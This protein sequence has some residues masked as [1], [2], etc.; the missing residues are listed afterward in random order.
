VPEDEARHASE[1][2]A[3]GDGPA[4]E[5]A[6]AGDVRAGEAVKA[7]RAGKATDASSKAGQDDGAAPAESGAAPPEP[8]VG[9]AASDTQSGAA[10]TGPDADGGAGATK[11]PLARAEEER[12]EYLALA[13]R[14]KADFE[15]YRRRAA[16][17]V[18]AAGARGRADVVREL[19]PVLD[20]LERALESVD[21]AEAP[22]AQGVRL[23]H[24]ELA[25]VLSRNGVE[26]I[27]PAGEAFDPNVH[28]A[29]STRSENGT[30]A[31]VVLDV[32]QR[33]YR[34]DQTVLRP[35]RV[36]VSA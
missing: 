19:L 6:K 12:A 18:A 11:D 9:A 28:E 10:A 16:R 4:D 32:V 27:D 14:T 24:S 2:A 36:V 3:D 35:A 8:E 17:D 15:N 23:V 31:G 26:A 22:L 20:N 5:G 25:A 34:L 7:G 33:G 29:L 13:Q 1:P 21:D 30:E